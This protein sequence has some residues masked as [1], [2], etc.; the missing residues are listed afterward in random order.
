M[1]QFKDASNGKG[2]VLSIT[3]KH[4]DDTINLIRL[5]RALNN[6]LP[7]QIIY[8]NDI[9][10]SS[11]TKII[12]AAREEINNFP[13]SYEKVYHG[14]QPSVPPSPPPPPQEVWFV[15][16]YESINPQHRNLFAKFDFK[17]LA[18]LFNSFNEFML[19]D[20]DTILMKSPE[21]FFNHQSYQ[22]TGAFFS[23]I[24][25]HYLNVQ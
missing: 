2:I 23:K 17:L 15:N 11:K 4:I 19:I 6:K 22:Q 25:H 9:S 10:Q 20:A 16:I 3:E 21:F 24:G 7:I 12:K 18:S 13:K 14:K 1:N 8:F 5:L